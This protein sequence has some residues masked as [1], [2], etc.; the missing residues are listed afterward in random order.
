MGVLIVGL[1]QTKWKRLSGTKSIAIVQVWANFVQPFVGF[2]Q[3]DNLENQEQS[4]HEKD[5]IGPFVVGGRSRTKCFV[6]IV[7]CLSRL[8]IQGSL[9]SVDNCENTKHCQCVLYFHS[10]T[11]TLVSLYK[12]FPIAPKPA[13]TDGCTVALAVLMPLTTTVIVALVTILIVIIKKFKDARYT[14]N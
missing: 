5:T 9:K 10:V 14:L 8:C 7:K 1:S 11:G 6:I 2:V 13:G 12:L 3:S 4:Q